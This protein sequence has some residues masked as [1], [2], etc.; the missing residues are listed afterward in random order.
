MKIA[1]TVPVEG[2]P[3]CYDMLIQCGETTHRLRFHDTATE[4]A[5]ISAP[6]H[7]DI[8]LDRY[9]ALQD[10]GGSVPPCVT[11]VSFISQLGMRQ[12]M[13]LGTQVIKLRVGDKV[14]VSWNTIEEALKMMNRV[15]TTTA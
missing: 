1:E 3:G 13:S 5:Y 12:F 11:L 2:M 14:D 9:V 8:P 4:N 15:R 10:L 7:P 6:D